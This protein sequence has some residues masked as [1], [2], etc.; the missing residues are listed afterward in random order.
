VAEHLTLNVNGM[1]CGGCENAV[2]RS[3]STLAGVSAVTASAKDHRVTVDFD[4]AKTTRA[5]IEQA[6]EKAGYEV[7]SAG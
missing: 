7:A 6:I 5:A 1:T 3:V 2:K 4:A